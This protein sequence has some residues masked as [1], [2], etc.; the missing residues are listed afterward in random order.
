M[1]ARV[2]V[3]R[4][5]TS[6]RRR[7]RSRKSGRILRCAKSSPNPGSA[8]KASAA[9]V[10]RQ[11]MRKSAIN[12][13]SDVTTLLVHRA[14]SQPTRF[15][16]VVASSMT[17]EASAPDCASSRCEAGSRVT[18]AMMRRRHP[19][20]TRSADSPSTRESANTATACMTAAT[21][22]A[23]ASQGK[24][25]P[26]RCPT[27]SSSSTLGAIGITNPA[28]RSTKSKIKPRTSFFRCPQTTSRARSQAVASRRSPISLIC[29]NQGGRARG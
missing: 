20:T 15:C 27:T 14:S 8:A 16:M 3:S 13:T 18:C 4:P 19:S 2:W 5:A 7:L 10:M 28:A 25:S 24:R 26:L 21:T 23:A 17:R 6:A 11:S 1:P 29:S 12:A 9:S 22:T